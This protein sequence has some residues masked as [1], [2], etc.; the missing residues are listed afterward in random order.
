LP[1]YKLHT[2]L[3]E[4]FSRPLGVLVSNTELEAYVRDLDTKD[5]MLVTVGDKTTEFFVSRGHRPKMQ[6]VDSV[7]KRRRRAPPV[8][9]YDR[10]VAVSNPAGGITGVAA[11]T[12]RAELSREGAAR[13]LVNGEE[14]LLVL[15][16]ILYSQ[17]GTDVFYGQPNEGMVHV[18]VSLE[19]RKAVA[20]MLSLL[21]F[22][23][24]VE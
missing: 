10:V 16:A 9:G 11:D 22:A 21:G 4:K 5:A 7:E 23:A 17:E 2:Y 3:R 13:I 15:P 20:G 1:F 24:S 8:G 18:R 14:D 19:T 6:I 12:I